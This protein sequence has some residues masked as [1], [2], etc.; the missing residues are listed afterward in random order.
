MRS[1]RR[2]PRRLR[3]VSGD[4]S[5]HA[6]MQTSTGLPHLRGL[7][8]ESAPMADHP[9][10]LHRELPKEDT[11]SSYAR[12]VPANTYQVDTKCHQMYSR[13]AAV[14][15]HK[16]KTEEDTF[17][18]SGL[19]DIG[20]ARLSFG[21]KIHAADDHFLPPRGIERPRW[22]TVAPPRGGQP[23]LSPRP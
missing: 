13:R 1:P 12:T 9:T 7:S 2:M 19:F 23:C 10:T 22:R 3:G 11:A 16:H 5:H 15:Q 17:H 6:T 21:P 14:A 20:A 8:P 4:H 18:F